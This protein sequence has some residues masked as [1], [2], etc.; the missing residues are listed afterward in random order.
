VKKHIV[1]YLIAFLLFP[2]ISLHAQMLLPSLQNGV[3]KYPNF[4]PEYIKK[5]NIKSLVFDIID[6]KDLQVAVDKGLIHSY[7]FN[8]NGMLT[9]FYYTV[10]SKTITQ[11]I[12]TGA[13][14]KKRKKISNGGVYFKNEYVYDTISTRFYYDDKNR[15]THSR[16]NDGAY[17]EALYY[18]YNEQDLITKIIR[19][20]ETNVGYDK[21][22]F[23]LGIQT[24]L[25]DE[26]FQYVKLV[27][28]QLKKLCLN[29]ENRVFKEIIMTYD[30]YKYITSLNEAFTAT[31]I[32]QESKFA[33]NYNH[34]MIEKTYKSNSGGTLQTKSTFEYDPKGNLL[35]EKQYKNDVLHNELSYLFD[36]SD[37]RV[38]SYLNRD[39]INKSIRITKVIYSFWATV[40][41][42]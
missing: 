36:D 16:Y 10:I 34:Q 4:N 13:V 15:L 17:Y 12:H 14:Y 23:Q 19:A 32:S 9:R 28:R 25:S 39:H 37:Q 41:E 18:E 1:K 38:K 8:K 30:E 6:K 33:Y 5:H 35:T 2:C 24:V 3:D 7:E 26:R 27:D 42:R 22:N 31:W 29:D 40:V 21:S 20:K 11:E